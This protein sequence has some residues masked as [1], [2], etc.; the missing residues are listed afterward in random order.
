L[1]LRGDSALF[2]DVDGTVLDI[3]P[4]PDAV[5]V[6]PGLVDALARLSR[7][8]GGALALVS[9][10]P[11]AE[12][13]RLF[14]GLGCPAAGQ[15]G[16]ELRLP[17]GSFERGRGQA[18]IPAALATDVEALARRWPEIVTEHKGLSI[19]VHF[20]AAPEIETELHRLLESMLLPFGKSLAMK[21]G[22][23]VREIVCRGTDKGRAVERFMGM[24]PFAGRRPIF[25]GDDVTDED[26]FAAAVRLGGVGL[27]VGEGDEG[28]ENRGHAGF[29][30]PAAV[31]RWLACEAA[32]GPERAA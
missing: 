2:L 9:G 4:R 16:A 14:P 1:S 6:P 15:H 17:D 10:R 27:G 30:S 5:L 18:G 13:D 24:Q 26:G 8:L 20:R 31:R 7:R 19:A 23:L 28:D 25:V 21:R 12:L 32:R 22:K 11:I 29:A 3:A